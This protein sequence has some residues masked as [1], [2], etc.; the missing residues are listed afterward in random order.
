MLSPER[1]ILH[2][3]ASGEP[4]PEIVLIKEF[5][6]GSVINVNDFTNITEITNPP[7]KTSILTIEPTSAQDTAKYSCQVQNRL[8][9]L[10]S[11]KAKVTILSKFA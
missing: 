1:A 6:N 3:L 5:A 7:N 10:T 4:L 2:C 8:H 9:L 11:G